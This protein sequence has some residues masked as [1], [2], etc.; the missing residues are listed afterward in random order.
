MAHERAHV[1]FS[2]YVQGVG[3]RFTARMLASH[4]PVTGYVRN[5]PDGTV[6]VEAEGER[7]DVESYLDGLRA[8]MKD[9]ASGAQVTWGPPA[10]GE[11]DFSV[12][13]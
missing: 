6:E 5:L 2:G 8:K 3:F 1:I 9:Y 12:R 11:E 4:F 7:S 13:F 10:G